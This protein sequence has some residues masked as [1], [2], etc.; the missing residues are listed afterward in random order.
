MKPYYMLQGDTTKYSLEEMLAAT[1][2]SASGPTRRFV[3]QPGSD[4]LLDLKTNRFVLARTDE[5]QPVVVLKR[6]PRPKVV[7]RYGAQMAAAMEN[8]D[9]MVVDSEVSPY[10]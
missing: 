7:G 3:T 6:K 9:R 1:M 2:S 10:S 8:N 4:Q 5:S